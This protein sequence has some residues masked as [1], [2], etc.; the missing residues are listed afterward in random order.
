MAPMKSAVMA[1]PAARR[2]RG[3]GRG[4]G[5]ASGEGLFDIAAA[6]IAAS[7]A[8]RSEGARKIGTMGQSAPSQRRA[9]EKSVSG[10]QKAISGPVRRF[11]NVPVAEDERSVRPMRMTA[12]KRQAEAMTGAVWR[13]PKISLS[14]GV[15]GAAWPLAALRRPER[16]RRRRTALEGIETQR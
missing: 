16:A 8:R 13:R 11:Q 7:G 14:I 5:W 10:R 6:H 9:V 1:R 2:R 3:R 4:G 12:T 15:P